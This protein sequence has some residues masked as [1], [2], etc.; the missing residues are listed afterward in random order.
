MVELVLGCVDC[1]E[2]EPPGESAC[3]P[4][5]LGVISHWGARPCKSL[6]TATH[7]LPASRWL[8]SN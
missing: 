7:D 5:V 4:D 8:V 2:P 6:Q 3:M 1:K